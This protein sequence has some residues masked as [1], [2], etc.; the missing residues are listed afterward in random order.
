MIVRYALL[1]LLTVC[2]DSC[3]NAVQIA[4]SQTP[5][6][7]CATS[8]S[9]ICL[10][11]CPSRD[12]RPRRPRRRLGRRATSRSRRSPSSS[13]EG[14]R[15]DPRKLVAPG[16]RRGVVGFGTLGTPGLGSSALVS[17]REA[18]PSRVASAEARSRRRFHAGVS[19]PAR[20]RLDVKE[21]GDTP[22]RTSGMGKV[23]APPRGSERRVALGE[24][25]RGHIGHLAARDEHGVP[26]PSVVARALEAA[27]NFPR[28]HHLRIR[29]EPLLLRATDIRVD[30][31]QAVAMAIAPPARPGGRAKRLHRMRGARV[32][33]IVAGST[34]A[35]AKCQGRTSR[36]KSDTMIGEYVRPVG[37]HQGL[38]V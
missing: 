13:A 21:V 15:R 4:K 1:A 19:H 36:H 3:S 23:R 11:V 17:R 9:P 38:G 34:R 22:S 2:G 6:S 5:P 12:H 33:L 16:T 35:R 31:P 28:R 14:S 24:R 10:G 26:T 29:S 20:R 32:P 8:P 18:P 7:A 27:K 25:A 37:S 30:H